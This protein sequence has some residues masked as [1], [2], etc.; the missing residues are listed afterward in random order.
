MVPSL[1]NLRHL[2]TMV[3]NGF[4]GSCLLRLLDSRL[5][6]LVY[7]GLGGVR[8]DQR[9]HYGRCFSASLLLASCCLVECDMGA[10]PCDMLLSE[11]LA[12]IT[13]CLIDK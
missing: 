5:Y 13:C 3:Y 2:V 6:V 1:W 8:E 11:K 7:C 10:V 9:F 4:R 12:A